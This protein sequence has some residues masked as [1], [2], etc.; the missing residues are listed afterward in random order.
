MSNDITDRVSAT[1]TTVTDLDQI[2]QCGTYRYAPEGDT[3]PKISGI[4]V[5]TLELMAGG[6]WKQTQV[7][8]DNSMSGYSL[9]RERRWSCDGTKSEWKNIPI[10][11]HVIFEQDTFTRP[12]EDRLRAIIREELSGSVAKSN[13]FYKP[14]D[15]GGTPV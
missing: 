14:V 12:Q 5:N 4:V 9:H 7:L 10:P 2:E 13:P 3:E 15:V 8:F 6:E 1:I 11:Q